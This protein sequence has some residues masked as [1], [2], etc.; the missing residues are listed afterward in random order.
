MQNLQVSKVTKNAIKLEQHLRINWKYPL[1][2]NADSIYK[3]VDG[4]I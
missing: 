4:Y 1:E 2:C 3:G